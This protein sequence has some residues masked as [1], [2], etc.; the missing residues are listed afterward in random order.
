VA[1]GV[2]GAASF[3][4]GVCRPRPAKHDFRQKI[5][6]NLTFFWQEHRQKMPFRI[7]QSAPF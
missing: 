6:E 3:F 2:M 5:S 4:W 1:A 7:H